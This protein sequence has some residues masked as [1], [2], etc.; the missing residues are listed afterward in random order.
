MAFVR[1]GATGQ[2]QPNCDVHLRDPRRRFTSTPAMP[3]TTSRLRNSG[4][5]RMK[6]E[7]NRCADPVGSSVASG[8]EAGRP[9]I[10]FSFD[11]FLTWE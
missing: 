5:S 10:D 11:R 3:E 7:I 1:R 6:S 8:L 4:N 2:F 9:C